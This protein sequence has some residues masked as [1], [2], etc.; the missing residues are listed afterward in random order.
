[1]HKACYVNAE[2]RP[3]LPNCQV[4]CV[5]LRL[6]EAACANPTHS[7][8]DLQCICFDLQEENNRS[9]AAKAAQLVDDIDSLRSE[10]DSLRSELD[11]QHAR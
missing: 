2:S 9:S 7:M 4:A 8:Q 10:L 6:Q 3:V 11:S 5:T 1:M